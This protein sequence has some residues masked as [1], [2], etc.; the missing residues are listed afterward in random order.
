MENH[1]E[2]ITFLIIL[3]IVGIAC[4]MWEC[5]DMVKVKRVLQ[6]V[7]SFIPSVAYDR[8][9]S[10]RPTIYMKLD[11]FKKVYIVNPDA[12][13]LYLI[14]TERT[15][16]GKDYVIGFRGLDFY[17]YKRWRKKVLYPLYSGGYDDTSREFMT[18][19]VQKDI[20]QL[21]KKAQ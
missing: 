3:L 21:T 9:G 6:R 10:D 16:N 4:Y 17:R 8:L 20:D 1:K 12:Y 5:V 2:F 13:R 14:T 7:F 15:Y 11:E 19:V 18:R